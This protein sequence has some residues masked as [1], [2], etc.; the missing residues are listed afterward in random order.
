MVLGGFLRDARP[1]GALDR[2]QRVVH[3]RAEP[4]RKLTEVSA[5]AAGDTMI[6]AGFTTSAARDVHDL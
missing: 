3:G 1:A 5:V 6:N 2:R 4:A